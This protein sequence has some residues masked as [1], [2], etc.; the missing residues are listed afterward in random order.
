MTTDERVK[1]ILNLVGCRGTLSE[2]SELISG[3]GV[4]KG[5]LT[6]FEENLPGNDNG[7]IINVGLV[8]D[9]Y[10]DFDVYTLPTNVE[11]V[12]YITEMTEL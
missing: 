1:A 12:H 5:E 4:E 9:R 6:P 3:L 8:G 10:L 2:L 7:F 11:N